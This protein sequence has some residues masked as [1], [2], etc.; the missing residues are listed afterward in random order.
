MVYVQQYVGGDTEVVYVNWLCGGDS[1]VVYIQQLVGGVSDSIKT[2][3]ML[4]LNRLR[5]GTVVAF[6][7]IFCLYI[8]HLK[9]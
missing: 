7:F 5:V 9:M 3:F 2:A 6:Q 8:C 4:K 1:V